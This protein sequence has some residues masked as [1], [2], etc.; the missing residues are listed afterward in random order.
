M[1]ALLL[2]GVRAPRHVLARLMAA[3]LALAVPMLAAP[4]AFAADTA[5]TA[6]GAMPQDGTGLLRATLGLA[7]VLALIF[8]V[9]WMMRRLSPARASGGALRIV[10]AQALGT[11]ERIVVVEVGEQWIVVGVAPGNVRGLA[12]LPR[13]TLPPET[14][15][16]VPGFAAL[17]ARATRR[18]SAP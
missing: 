18:T 9:G 2:R 4:V 6:T 17:L 5:G 3:S 14:P 1:N 16:A 10:G 8:A 12:T 15:P 13:G 11:R 7:L